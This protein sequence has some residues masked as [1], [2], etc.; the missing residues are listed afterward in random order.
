[1]VFTFVSLYVKLYVVGDGIS[2]EIPEIIPVL[3]PPEQGFFVY[4][5]LPHSGSDIESA[6]K[7]FLLRPL[8]IISYGG[9]TQH[10]KKSSVCGDCSA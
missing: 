8:K 4:F 7:G 10:G 2:L 1:M 9:S 3:S 5:D 6:H